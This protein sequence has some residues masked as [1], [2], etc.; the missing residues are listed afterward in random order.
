MLSLLAEP[1]GWLLVVLPALYI[2][3]RAPLVTSETLHALLPLRGR[4]EAARAVIERFERGRRIDLWAVLLVWL[5][6]AA[7]PALLAWPAFAF[8]CYWF[9][10]RA[11]ARFEWLQQQA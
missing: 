2:L 6:T 11:R 7:L 10:E 1:H 5:V 9:T 4:E 8:S 3:L